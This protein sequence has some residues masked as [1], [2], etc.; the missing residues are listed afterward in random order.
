[1]AN[2]LNLED[3]VDKY[4]KQIPK[5]RSWWFRNAKE[6]YIGTP[7]V[8]CD[9]YFEIYLLFHNPSNEVLI[10]LNEIYL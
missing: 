2:E 3:K 8:N 7:E 5:V 1:M 9:G 4:V 10:S 6:G